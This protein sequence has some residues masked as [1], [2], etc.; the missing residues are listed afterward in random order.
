[1]REV[2][3]LLNHWDDA[4]IGGFIVTLI[5]HA[6]NTFPTPKSPYWAWFIGLIQFAVGQRI[7]AL[8]TMKGKETI[9]TGVTRE[10][11]VTYKN[12]G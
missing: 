11:K 8:N 7:A 9:A 10:E 4:L 1:V 6:V 2:S 12:G 5:A 3:H